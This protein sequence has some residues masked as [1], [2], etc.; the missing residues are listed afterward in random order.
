M[1]SVCVLSAAL[2]SF[3]AGPLL[4][5]AQLASDTALLNADTLAAIRHAGSNNNTI[6]TQ[7]GS[8]LKAT[9]EIQGSNNVGPGGAPNTITQT[10]S[11]SSANV[12]IVGDFNEFSISQSGSA[13]PAQN[14][15]SINIIGTNNRAQ[16]NQLNN[17]SNPYSNS[18]YI[19]QAGSFNLAE[20]AQT[21]TDT[22]GGGAIYGTSNQASIFQNGVENTARVEQDGTGNEA[23]IEQSGDNN[24]G[25]ITQL[26]AGSR[27]SLVQ[28]GSYNDYV[29]VQ[30]GCLVASCPGVEV[31]QTG[32]A[33][34]PPP[35]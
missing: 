12:G 16:I 11:G 32:G 14:E 22:S 34:F 28:N 8:D 35:S 2:V 15:A 20:I 29:M 33:S 31:T 30:T 7:D 26:G 25:R 24:T 23:L 21:I 5:S 1:K 10:G 27:L 9:V 3:C 4:A 6:V 13:G 17:L 18:A 19:Q